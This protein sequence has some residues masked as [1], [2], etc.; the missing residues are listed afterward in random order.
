MAV[1]VLMFVVIDVCQFWVR[2]SFMLRRVVC[3]I[4][5]KYIYVRQG[6]YL[7]PGIC[8]FVCWFVCMLGTLHKLLREFL[9]N[10]SSWK[11]YHRCTCAPYVYLY[12]Y[13]QGRQLSRPTLA[14]VSFGPMHNP[15]ITGRIHK[16][17][18]GSGEPQKSMRLNLL[19]FTVFY[20]G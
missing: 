16:S 14:V 2:F 13:L 4:C 12:L 17:L 19:E 10:G 20:D 11:F 1:D 8:L 6:R 18:W 5:V 7:M 15:K 3:T 9:L